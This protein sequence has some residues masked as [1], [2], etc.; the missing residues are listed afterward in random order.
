MIST[1][2]S[3]LSIQATSKRSPSSPGW[4]SF[5]SATVGQ[6]S[7]G[8]D[9]AGLLKFMPYFFQAMPDAKFRVHDVIATEGR[10]V[11]RWTVTGTVTGQGGFLG[12]E[13]KGQKLEFDGIDIWTVRNGRLYEHWD[14]F[15]WPRALIQLG[16]KSL[17]SPF[18]G[19]A[20]QPYS[21]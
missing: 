10:V 7:V 5:T 20:S 2:S 6:F 14:Q 17:P 19:V 4:V 18:Y 1:D 21:R 9:R 15:D 3:W 13:P 16:V 12:V 11:T 8:G